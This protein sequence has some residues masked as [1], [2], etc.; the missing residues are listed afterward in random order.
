MKNF[1][2]LIAQEGPY[3]MMSESSQ[4]QV[5]SGGARARSETR[6]SH[7]DPEEGPPYTEFERENDTRT[8]HTTQDETVTSDVYSIIHQ[9]FQTKKNGRKKSEAATNQQPDLISEP[10]DTYTVMAGGSPEKASLQNFNEI[11]RSMYA[12]MSGKQLPQDIYAVS[13]KSK[14]YRSI[15]EAEHDSTYTVISHAT[16]ITGKSPI[17]A[18]ALKVIEDDNPYAEMKGKRLP[19]EVSTNTKKYRS[20]NE[21]EHDSTYTVISHTTSS[22]PQT[23]SSRQGD[24]AADIY[25]VIPNSSTDTTRQTTPSQNPSVNY[26]PEEE[27]TYAVMSNSKSTAET[28]NLYAAVEHSSGVKKTTHYVKEMKDNVMYMT[29]P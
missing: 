9:K 2:D 3:T 13:K 17:K 20:T 7:Q 22:K 21:A 26:K 14:K 27:D 10:A 19:Q 18:A 16:T 1:E 24:V 28:N 15:N 23:S 5:S 6:A 12:E 29:A 8:P 25:A 4:D 11:Q